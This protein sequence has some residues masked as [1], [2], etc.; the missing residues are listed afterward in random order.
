MIQQLPTKYKALPENA[1]G[2]EPRM[3]TRVNISNAQLIQSLVEPISWSLWVTHPCIGEQ[4]V[5]WNLRWC[6]TEYSLHVSTRRTGVVLHVVAGQKQQPQC[7]W[8]NVP[9]MLTLP[10]ARQVTTYQ[11]IFNS[12]FLTLPTYMANDIPRYRTWHILKSAHQRW[13]PVIQP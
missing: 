5:E 4:S 10:S 6:H 2:G 3:T 12:N 8:G 13:N 7:I 9:S 1:V 11:H